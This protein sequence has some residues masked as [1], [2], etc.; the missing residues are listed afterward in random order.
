MPAI[1][2]LV[3]EFVSVAAKIPY[4]ILEFT[5]LSFSWVLRTAGLSVFSVFSAFSGFQGSRSGIPVFRFFRFFRLFWF[6]GVQAPI[7]NSGFSVFFRF[8]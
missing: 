3:L 5:F 2:Y 7:R 4:L 6:S 8:F 1:P